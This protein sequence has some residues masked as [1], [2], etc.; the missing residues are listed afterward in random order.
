[1]PGIPSSNPRQFVQASAVLHVEEVLST[2]HH[3]RD[4]LGFIWDFGDE[5]YAVVWRDNAAVHFTRDENAPRGV[6][7][8]L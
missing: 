4:E 1:M 2:A 6:P 3:Y 5:N 8:F 7:L